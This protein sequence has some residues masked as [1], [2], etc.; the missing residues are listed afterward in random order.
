L[1]SER[2]QI[3]ELRKSTSTNGVSSGREASQI[4]DVQQAK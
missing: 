1:G 2:S 3:W 4:A